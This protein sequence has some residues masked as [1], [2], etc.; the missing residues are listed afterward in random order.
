MKNEIFGIAAVALLSACGASKN[1]ATFPAIEG[2]WDIIEVDGKKLEAGAGEQRPFIGFDTKA[3]RVYG[4]SGCNR[5]MSTLEL[6]EKRGTLEMKQPAS[7]MMACPDMETERSILNALREVKGYAKSGKDGVALRNA[8]KHP[9]VILKKRS[10]PMAF[11]ELEGTWDV[12]S[13][14]GKSV[15]E[16]AKRKPFLTFDTK[17]RK[18]GGSM[19]CN[20]LFG[21]IETDENEKTAVAFTSVGT[22]MMACPDAETERDMRSAVQGVRNFGKLAGG[23][24]ALYDSDGAEAVVLRKR[25]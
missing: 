8:G 9:V 25:Q 4:Y 15:K 16:D 24:V 1:A 12:V 10:A 11:E 22:T 7:T 3:G 6:N 20:R 2:E 14:Y 21:N 18:L 23:D 5:L 17:N 19:S 13:I